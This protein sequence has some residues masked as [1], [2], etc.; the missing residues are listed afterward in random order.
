VKFLHRHPSEVDLTIDQIC[1]V[2]VIGQ[3]LE[4]QEVEMAKAMR[5]IL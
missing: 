5:G 2:A 1:E 4:K 3:D